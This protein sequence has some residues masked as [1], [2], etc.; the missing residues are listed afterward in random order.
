MRGDHRE[1]IGGFG[2]LND[3]VADKI[4]NEA[5]GDTQGHWFVAHGG[6]VGI[7]KQGC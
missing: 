4:A 2:S 1:L 5:I 3:L 7:Y 6:A